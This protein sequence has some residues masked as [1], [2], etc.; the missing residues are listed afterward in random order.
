MTRMDWPDWAR[1]TAWTA[2]A[3]V[4][5]ALP[6]A[7]VLDVTAWKSAVTAGITTLC[8]AVLVVARQ[9]AGGGQ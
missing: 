2:L 3:A 1:R 4:L 9:Q 8:T 6:A 7:T 5:S